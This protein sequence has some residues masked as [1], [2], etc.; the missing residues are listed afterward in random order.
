MAL[1]CRVKGAT[2]DQLL[3]EYDALRTSTG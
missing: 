2:V 3:D 1:Q